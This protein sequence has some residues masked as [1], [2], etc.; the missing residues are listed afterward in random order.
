MAIQTRT[1]NTSLTEIYVES[2]NYMTES[3]PTNFHTFRRR[4]ILIN[5]EN[6]G[7]YKEVTEAEKSALEEADAK[8][9]KPS[10]EL[11]SR[12]DSEWWLNPDNPHTK[13]GSYN[14][15][16]GF[17]EG[18]GVLDITA[19]QAARILDIGTIVCARDPTTP[20]PYLRAQYDRGLPTLLPFV[21]TDNLMNL[22]EIRA[23]TIRYVPLSELPSGEDFDDVAYLR[24][25]NFFTFVLKNCEVRH[26][27]GPLNIDQLTSS[28]RYIETNGKFTTLETIWLVG[29]NCRIGFSA[30]PNLRPECVHY[31]VE[32]A[33]ATN[34]GCA[35]KLHPEAYARV[36]DETFALAATENITIETTA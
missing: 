26:I 9:V 35:I 27:K 12:W 28:S 15:K 14:K 22:T 7:D 1:V 17:F 29:L 36:T 21:V 32:F 8:W 13:F 25:D 2:N 10:D 11:I 23:Q 30:H 4:K 31:M 19:A 18:N 33:D 5:G 24:G 3:F 20:A 6:I 16:T 34:T